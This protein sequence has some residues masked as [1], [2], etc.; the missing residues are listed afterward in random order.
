LISTR[1]RSLLTWTFTGALALGSAGACGGKAAE[2][3]GDGDAASP[4]DGDGGGDG[5]PAGT[6]GGSAS[7]GNATAGGSTGN[8]GSTGTGGEPTF[9]WLCGNT[10]DCELV[11]GAC[12]PSCGQQTLADYIALHV[13]QLDDYLESMCDEDVG[14][15]MCLAEPNPNIYA[16]CTGGFCAAVDLRERP[17]SACDTTDD[18]VLLPDACC[19]CGAGTSES[20]V[21]AINAAQSDDFQASQCSGTGP[22]ACDACLW[23][24]PADLVAECISGRCQVVPGTPEPPDGGLGGANGDDEMGGPT[25]ASQSSLE[26]YLANRRY[27]S[28]LWVGD[29]FTRSSSSPANV[30]GEELRVYFN[31]AALASTQTGSGIPEQGAMLVLELYENDVLI[32]QAATLKSGAGPGTSAWTYYCDAPLGSTRCTG[33]MEQLPLYGEGLTE[34]TFCHSEIPLAPLP[35]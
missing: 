17:D 35:Q 21:V 13:G 2:N 32:G 9:N 31:P 3:G 24:P 27:R 25:D 10:L 26:S 6:G 1:H 14:C 33:S 20:E 29:G 19:E 4:G 28:D 11:P 5:E 16:T 12:C 30:H 8:G 34:C 23:T 7:G 18:C 22:I 15:P